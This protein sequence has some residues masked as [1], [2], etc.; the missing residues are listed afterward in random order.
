MVKFVFV[1]NISERPDTHI[2]LSKS[3]TEV[4]SLH[5]KEEYEMVL[6]AGLF[7]IFERENSI[8]GFSVINHQV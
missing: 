2:F 4:S 7:K 8:L 3:S 6:M 1:F 5:E